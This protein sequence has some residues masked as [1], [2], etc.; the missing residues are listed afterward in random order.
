MYGQLESTKDEIEGK[1]K[2]TEN[3]SDKDATET[4]NEAC[5]DASL[6]PTSKLIHRHEE[7]YSQFS[8]KENALLTKNYNFSSY[9]RNG[10]S[11][12]QLLVIHTTI[13]S[14]ILKR[15]ISYAHGATHNISHNSHI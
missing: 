14:F 6:S 13:T 4:R 11:L 5:P 12:F 7:I 10:T 3:V 8:Q 2:Y 15:N 9:A 1:I